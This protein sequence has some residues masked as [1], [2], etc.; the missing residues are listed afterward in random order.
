[1]LGTVL[2]AHFILV[3]NSLQAYKLIVEFACLFLL[4]SI[5]SIQKVLSEWGNLYFKEDCHF[6]H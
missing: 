2:G 1:M 4:I 3:I 5:G 6:S